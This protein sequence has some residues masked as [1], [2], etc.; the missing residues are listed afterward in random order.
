MALPPDREASKFIYK[1]ISVYRQ[2]GQKNGCSNLKTKSNRVV[3]D[4]VFEFGISFV[5]YYYA[6]FNNDYKVLIVRTLTSIEY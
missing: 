1:V 6:C 3:F 5:Y 4:L 2:H